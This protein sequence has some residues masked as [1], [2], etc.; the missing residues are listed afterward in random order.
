MTM[1]NEVR[2]L[3]ARLRPVAQLQRL[4]AHHPGNEFGPDEDTAAGAAAK[5]G[6][7]PARPGVLGEV[8][9]FDELLLPHLS[10]RIDT[11][12]GPMRATYAVIGAR[13]DRPAMRR[14]LLRFHA[15]A[16]VV[17]GEVVTTR[18]ELWDLLVHP[19]CR[20]YWPDTP[21]GYGVEA[22]AG[23]PVPV[24]DLR[25]KQ[26]TVYTPIVWTIATTTDSPPQAPRGAVAPPEPKVQLITK[27]DEIHA[28]LPP[29][30]RQ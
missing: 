21:A 1:L 8:T 27:R 20:L 5:R 19:I 3:L 9:R 2:D 15:P 24:K 29:R 28:A 26:I 14:L 16:I 25:T 11:P 22:N 6:T 13:E 7:L 23:A 17:Q 12:S 30:G 10:T 4:V 18:D